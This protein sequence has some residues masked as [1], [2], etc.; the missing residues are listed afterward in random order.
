MHNI[1]WSMTVACLCTQLENKKAILRFLN[2][3]YVCICVFV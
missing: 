3:L 1:G 2:F